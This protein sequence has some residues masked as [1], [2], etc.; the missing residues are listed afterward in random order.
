MR[1]DDVPTARRGWQAVESSQWTALA[2]EV[3][4]LG[5][6]VPIAGGSHW[7][8]DHDYNAAQAAP[9]LDLIDDRL[10]YIAPGWV[11]PEHRSLL[12]A[13]EN[14]LAGMAAR[15]RKPDRPYV[16]GQ[17]AVPTFGAWAAPFEGAD[18]IVAAQTAATGDWDA[19]I[20]RGVFLFPQ[21]WGA[22]AAGI[23]GGEDIFSLPEVINGIPQIF[24][25][26][27]HAA[28]IVRDA[29]GG[30]TN[31][32]GKPTSAKL[33]SPGRLVVDTPHTRGLVGWGLDGRLGSA[34][35]DGLEVVVADADAV[36]LVSSLGPEPVST[37]KRLLVTAIGRVEPTGFRFA[38]EWRR[39]PGEPGR[40]PLL[41]GGVRAQVV[42]TRGGNIQAFALDNTGARVK[43]ARVE[44]V[45]GPAAGFGST[46][47]VK[48]ASLHWELVVE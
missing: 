1:K 44:K 15:K 28:S 8:R 9:G 14:G 39:E 26:L 27:P 40:P 32:A 47:T 7:K 36:V 17:Y 30:G 43:P 19:L 10:Y 21:V 42:W 18:L 20:R 6:R 34:R 5:L 4:K 29:A 11:A 13:G 33:A 38:D 3:R 16:V 41:H 37:S 35:S 2:G 23:G 45:E 46:S 25:L 31:R 24:A 12:W 22:S 48:G